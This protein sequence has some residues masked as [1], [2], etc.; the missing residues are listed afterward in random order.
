LVREMIA[1]YHESRP[2]QAKDSEL[3]VPG[4]EPKKCEEPDVMRLSE[5]GCKKRLGGAGWVPQALL[6]E[7]GVT[8]SPRILA[9]GPDPPRADSVGREAQRRHTCCRCRPVTSLP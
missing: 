5:I 2:H 3:L 8:P 6:P 9:S 7:G 1:Y 4:E